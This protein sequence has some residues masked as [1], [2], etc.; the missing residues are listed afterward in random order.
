M[1]RYDID[2]L[3][4]RNEALVRR[5]SVLVEGLLEPYFRAE[6]RGTE[7]IPPGAALYVGNHNAGLMQPDSFL[8]GAA[9]L[10]A[11]GFSALPY[12]LGHELAIRLPGIHQIIMPLGVVRAS[13]DNAHRLFRRGSKV[14]VFPGGDRDA[15]RPY[16]DRNR[17]VFGGRTG[18][19][20]LS[21]R[22]GVPI[23]PVVSAGAHSTLLILDDGQ[24]LAR[25]LRADRLLR[26][27]TWPIT[28]CLPWGLVVGPQL[29]YLP[30]PSRILIEILEP[31]RFDRTG[32]AAA[33]DE[34][35]VRTCADRV[36]G[37]MQEA[38]DRL[39]RERER[40]RALR[41]RGA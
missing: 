7:R 34:A 24:W 23:I 1:R 36:E 21:L 33:K 27:K 2:S 31:I 11:H 41:R 3:D 39:V 13:H 10:R 30:W 16:R 20:R 35:Y 9:V 15:M 6:V 32:D 37:T 38:L 4:N 25:L 22:E 8:F 12:G 28:I 29:L 18:Y 14:L 5:L 40:P 19:M 26:I 17:V